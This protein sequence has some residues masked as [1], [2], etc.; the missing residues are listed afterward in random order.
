MIL[1]HPDH[2]TKAFSIHRGE[3]LVLQMVQDTFFFELGCKSC[4]FSLVGGKALLNCIALV[5]FLNKSLLRSASGAWSALYGWKARAG[6]AGIPWDAGCEMPVR[7]YQRARKAAGR[8]VE[9]SKLQ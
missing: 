4:S 2:I 7:R 9:A 5:T 3:K 1:H 6:R 8:G